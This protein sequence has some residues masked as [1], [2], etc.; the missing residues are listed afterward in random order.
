MAGKKDAKQKAGPRGQTE[1]NKEETKSS[2][3]TKNASEGSGQRTAQSTQQRTPQEQEEQRPREGAQGQKKVEGKDIQ[4]GWETI[5]EDKVLDHLEGRL[6][7]VTA[8]IRQ[9]AVQ[10][11][12][13]ELVMPEEGTDRTGSRD[14][15]EDLEQQPRTEAEAGPASEGGWDAQQQ[16]TVAA[17]AHSRGMQPREVLQALVNSMEK[18]LRKEKGENLA[19]QTSSLNA[20]QREEAAGKSEVKPNPGRGGRDLRERKT[21]NNCVACSKDKRRGVPPK[22]RWKEEQKEK[23]L[24]QDGQDREAQGKE[25]RAAAMPNPEEAA[26]VPAPGGSEPRCVLGE[27]K[28]GV[29][30]SKGENTQMPV[31]CVSGVPREPANAGAVVRVTPT[32]SGSGGPQGIMHEINQQYLRSKYKFKE[33]APL[34]EYL[35]QRVPSLGDTCT[36]W[37]VLTRLKEIIRDNLLFDE[38]NPAM[39]VGDAPLE[40]ALGMKKVHVNEIRGVVQQRLMLVEAS[41]GPLSAR[42]LAGA[43]VSERAAPSNPRPETRAATPAPPMG[44]S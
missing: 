15:P 1:K 18:T 38:S 12:A 27:V 5:Q 6:D 29:G 19:G 23:A 40:A 20:S 21:E 22:T 2:A 4:E 28:K 31:A 24:G 43:M 13:L 35:R 32:G 37:E 44:E 11:K 34:K 26:A 25:N 30:G 41:Q 8:A 10:G 33:G 9:V 36:L 17:Y 3:G 42:M 7:R 16:A 14:S 39:I